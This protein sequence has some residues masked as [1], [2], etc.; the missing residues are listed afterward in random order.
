[1]MMLM[2]RLWTL[3]KERVIVPGPPGFWT[4]TGFRQTRC[5]VAMLLPFDGQK[6]CMRW[7]KKGLLIWRFLSFLKLDWGTGFFLRRRF[8]FPEGVAGFGLGVNL[9]ADF[10]EVLVG[11]PGVWP[12]SS[13]VHWEPTLVGYATWIGF[14]VGMVCLVGLMSHPCLFV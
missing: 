10:F 12:G 1:M 6:G 11:S 5:A 8:V 2:G 3:C 14:S 4:M 9:L 7:A 13:L